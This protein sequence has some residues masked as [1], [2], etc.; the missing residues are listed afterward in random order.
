[1]S[2]SRTVNTRTDNGFVRAGSFSAPAA[3][4]TRIGSADLADEEL[5]AQAVPTAPNVRTNQAWGKN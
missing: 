2:A 1:M 3:D 5:I 4:L